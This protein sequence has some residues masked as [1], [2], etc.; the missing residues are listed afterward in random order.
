MRTGSVPG[1]KARIRSMSV[2]GAREEPDADA[3]IVGVGGE[4]AVPVAREPGC[5]RSSSAAWSP[6]S[7][8]AARR[9]RSRS[10][11]AASAASLRVESRLGRAVRVRARPEE[12][13]EVPGRDRQRHP[14]KAWSWRRTAARSHSVRHRRGAVRRSPSSAAM[15]RRTSIGAPRPST[16]SPSAR[17]PRPT[18]G[19]VRRAPGAEQLGLQAVER[20]GLLALG[21]HLLEQPVGERLGPGRGSKSESPSRS[22]IAAIRDLVLGGP[23]QRRLEDVGLGRECQVV[24]DSDTSASAATRRCVTAATPS[25][26]TIRTVA[27]TMRRGPAAR[28][29]RGCAGTAAESTGTSVLAK[30]VRTY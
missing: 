30:R 16:C 20:D 12:V 5:S 10:I 15:T 2:S 11:I 29:R 3:A 7:W 1:G 27:P 26:A 23:V 4:R 9:E 6:T 24:E 13:L 18:R 19:A 28:P 22:A 25:R 14:S 17:R 8:T 21:R